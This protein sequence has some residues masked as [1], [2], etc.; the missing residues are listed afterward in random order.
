[1]IKTLEEAVVIAGM[2]I[3]LGGLWAFAIGGMVHMA[4][5]TIADPLVQCQRARKG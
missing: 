1:M 2:L 3:G 5:E 4:W